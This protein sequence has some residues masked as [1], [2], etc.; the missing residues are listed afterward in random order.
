M[1]NVCVQTWQQMVM[2][3]LH[4]YGQILFLTPI[5]MKYPSKWLEASVSLVLNS[6]AEDNDLQAKQC[7]KSKP[8]RQIL[9]PKI[10][11]VV[12]YL[13]TNGYDL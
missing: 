2:P 11:S 4:F 8:G 6:L 3:E 13:N 7:Q 10:K 1:V 9:I 5:K 12:N